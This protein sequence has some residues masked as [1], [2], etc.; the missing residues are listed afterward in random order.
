MLLAASQGTAIPWTPEQANPASALLAQMGAGSW[1]G[2]LTNT[3]PQGL[4]L[5]PTTVP[6]PSEEGTVDTIESQTQA[7][8]EK[9]KSERGN[10][11]MRTKAHAGC[12]AG[13]T[14]I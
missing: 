8:T 14:E 10:R 6:T 3:A 1:P 7:E 13:I 5:T 4:P 12:T 9:G 2:Q 11:P